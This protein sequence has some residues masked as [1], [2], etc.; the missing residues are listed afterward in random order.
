MS[1]RNVGKSGAAFLV[2]ILGLADV[3]GR[4]GFGFIADFNLVP[5]RVIF[6]G[7]MAAAGSL[8]SILPRIDN[9]LGL[10]VMCGVTGE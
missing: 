9:Y 4:I 8:V 7:C 2:S 6:I 3:V 5:K 1:V 10:A